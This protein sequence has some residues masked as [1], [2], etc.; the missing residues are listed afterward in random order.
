MSVHEIVRNVETHAGD[1]LVTGASGG[2]G[3]ISV[4]ILSRLGYSV[5]A[6]SG[7]PDSAAFLKGLGAKESFPAMPCWMTAENRF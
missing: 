2:V 1:I 4:A 6:V 7:K 3:S 5:V